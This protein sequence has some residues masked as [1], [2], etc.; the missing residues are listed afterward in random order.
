MN[1]PVFFFCAVV[2]NAAMAKP[3]TCP[4]SATTRLDSAASPLTSVRVL[5]FASDEPLPTNGA[6]P[7]HAPD[8][9]VYGDH[10]VHQTWRVNADSPRYKYE[11]HCIYGEK[12]KSLRFVIPASATSC[13]ATD[14]L[15]TSKF[16]MVCR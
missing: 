15:K 12:K 3:L 10:T 7:T 5:S 13:T 9:E 1:W 11:L 2:G 4:Q 14:D 6:L 8:S 16:T